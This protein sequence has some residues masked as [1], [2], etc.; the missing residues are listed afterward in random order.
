MRCRCN[1]SRVT[2]AVTLGSTCSF[3]SHVLLMDTQQMCCQGARTQF[4]KTGR[5]RL[6]LSTDSSKRTRFSKPQAGQDHRW[7]IPPSPLMTGMLDGWYS[8]RIKE[9]GVSSVKHLWPAGPHCVW[10]KCGSTVSS[11]EITF[12]KHKVKQPPVCLAANDPAPSLCLCRP[13]VMYSLALPAV[14]AERT[15]FV[16]QWI[17][18]R[19]EPRAMFAKGALTT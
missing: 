6:L 12:S 3:R 13:N 9:T 14:Y 7:M 18:E 15:F 4:C 8:N 1:V 2:V 5:E 11:A 10:H 19:L 16:S 17:W